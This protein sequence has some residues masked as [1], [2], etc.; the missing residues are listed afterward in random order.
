MELLYT[1][2][3]GLGAVSFRPPE[4]RTLFVTIVSP[5]DRYCGNR[6]Q[7]TSLLGI[8][9]EQECGVDI[10]ISIDNTGINQFTQ[11]KYKRNLTWVFPTVMFN[12]ASFSSTIGVQELYA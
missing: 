2:L 3:H 9:V 6:V 10:D 4:K 5:N 7:D 12:R 11:P 8:K 1:I